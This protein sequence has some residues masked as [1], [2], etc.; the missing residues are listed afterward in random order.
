VL[1][2]GFATEICHN[3]RSHERPLTHVSVYMCDGIFLHFNL[4]DFKVT[5]QISCAIGRYR[6]AV[7]LRLP[8]LRNNDMAGE[9]SLDAEA[10]LASLF[11]F[12]AF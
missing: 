3:A 8:A 9:R 5:S 6:S 2:V 4:R 11:Y 1:L 10:T 7:L 12:R